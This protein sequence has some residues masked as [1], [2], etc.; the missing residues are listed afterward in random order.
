M[1]SD[2]IQAKYDELD[3]IAR[4]FG[5]QAQGIGELRSQL[6]RSAQ[7]LEQGGW[8]GRGSAAFFKE[9]NGQVVPATQRLRQAL[10]EARAVTL[11][12]SELLRR[13][14]QEAS[15]PFRGQAE[16]GAGGA[17]GNGQAS[18]GSGP[19]ESGG[20]SGARIA[21]GLAAD[22]T[23]VVGELK[24][25]V[26]I[27]TGKDLVTGEDLGWWRFAGILG[28]VGLNEVKHLRHA[29]DVIDAAGSIARKGD[30]VADA[31]KADA[32][33]TGETDATRIGKDVHKTQADIRRAS[34]EFDL[35][36]QAITDTSGNPILVPHRVDLETGLPQPGTRMQ[37]AIPDAVKFRDGSII[38]D[39]PL[40]RPIAKDRQEMIRF[41]KAYELREGRLPERIEIHRY[42][43]ST[44]N[45]SRIEIYTPDDFLPK[46][47]NP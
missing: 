40:G 26:E 35:V 33:K 41:I 25:F 4:R 31:R 45:S 30:D 34:G 44:G 12:I 1:A 36:N 32:V 10:D 18:A 27:F 37:D 23:P 38:D 20:P 42:D 6:Q 22:F 39:K 47:K 13:A 8:Q 7:P 9:M 28:V 2:V 21:A 24:G 43:P 46:P 11:Q 5:Q 14:E 3:T 16:A 17:D 15:A 29:D 19:T